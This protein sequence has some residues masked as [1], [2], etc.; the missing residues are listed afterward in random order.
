MSQSPNDRPTNPTIAAGQT[1]PTQEPRPADV[2][3]PQGETPPTEAQAED[4]S[5]VGTGTAIA[6]ILTVLVVIVIAIGGLVAL[7]S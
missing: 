5:T 6:L 4:L 2:A 7:L 3:A 1:E